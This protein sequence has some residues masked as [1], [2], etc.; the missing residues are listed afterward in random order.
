MVNPCTLCSPHSME[1]YH[2]LVTFPSNHI[3]YHRRPP[4]AIFPIEAAQIGYSTGYAAWLIYE[5]PCDPV[6]MD[7]SICIM[8]TTHSGM[9]S[10]VGTVQALSL[11]QD[12]WAL[13]HVRTS[14]TPIVLCVPAG[15]ADVGC[16]ISRSSGITEY[17]QPTW[18]LRISSDIF[19]AVFV[20]IHRGMLHDHRHSQISERSSAET[21]RPHAAGLQGTDRSL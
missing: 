19:S 2:H 18:L 4:S 20:P 6:C 12:G 11:V 13:F 10:L 14:T 9:Q 16:G 15:W 17:W 21:I 7:M 1:S 8:P 5:Q 3:R